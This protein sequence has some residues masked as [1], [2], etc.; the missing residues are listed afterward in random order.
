MAARQCR[1]S[2]QPAALAVDNVVTTCIYSSAAACDFW[3]QRCAD[4]VNCNLCLAEMSN[5]DNALEAVASWLTTACQEALHDRFA[6]SYLISITQGCPGISACRVAVTE[7]VKADGGTFIACINGSAPSGYTTFCSELMQ[8][9]SIDSKC[10]SCPTSVHTINAVVFATSMVGGVSAV[11]CLAVA[12]T[13]VA[14]RRDRVSMRDRIVVGLMMANA[15]YSTANAIPLNA[16]R[17]SV[18]H[19]G[20]LA[21]SF[22]AIRFGRAWWFCGKYGLVSFEL[23]IL[24]ASIQALLG[25][26]SAVSARTEAATYAA[27]CAIAALAFAVFYALCSAINADG[28]NLNA[29]NEAYTNAY[30][31]ASANDDLDDDEP[32]V[33]ASETYTSARDAYDN[34]V[35]DMLVVW[36]VVVGVAVGL[37][38]VVRALHHYALRT[39]RT[40]EAEVARAE[41]ADEWAATRQS[42]WNARRSLLETRRD[43]FNEVAK[44]LEPYIAV[45]VVFA[46]PAVIMSTPFCQNRSGAIKASG[47]SVLDNADGNDFTYGTCD[48][49]CEFVLAFRSLGAVAVYLLARERRAELVAVRSTW[50]K[51]CVRAMACLRCKQLPYAPLDDHQA[52]WHEMQEL[53]QRSVDAA[54]GTNN[55]TVVA[56]AAASENVASWHMNESDITLVKVLGSGAFGEVWEGVKKCDGHRVA[57]KVMRA[58][59]VDEDGDIVDLNADEDFRKECDA[60][61]RVS[62]PHL[63]TFYGFGTTAAGSGFIVTELMLGGSLEDV[64]HDTERKLPWET[65]MKIALQVALGMEHLHQRHMLHRDL[66]SANVL[67]DEELRAKVSDF[68]LS[69]VVRPARRQVVRSSFSGVTRLLPDGLYINNNSQKQSVLSLARIAVSFS[70]SGGNLTKAAGTLL[71]M[72]PEVYRGDQHYTGAVDVYSFGIVLWELATRKT[73]WAEEL[74]SN[75]VEFIE[76]LNSALQ[77]GRRPELPDTMR[78]EQSAFVAVMEKCWAG[79]PTDRPAFSKVV[80]DL[81]ACV[82][83]NT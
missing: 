33:S 30:N 28:Y 68:G 44:P 39:L 12:A 14:H 79:D 11:A 75:Q 58:G 29:E 80:A 20:R 78:T 18:I 52:A 46:A 1:G 21:M 49:W 4:N 3:R 65:R 56:T 74:P 26:M 81:A 66:K 73:P 19:Y 69:R 77:K 70:D 60:L 45:F 76:G 50:R 71:W 13:I 17:T 43:A 35:R 59:A 10:Q 62:S 61:Q 38:I 31:H 32:S 16:L 54:V 41:A 47:A 48:V 82:R 24:G 27:C 15:V 53:E 37:W 8:E 64:L 63:L 9:Y 40:E 42:A 57:V 22:D 72:A 6:A 36:D 34:L 67:L 25:G 2:T 7:G 55:I 23:V 5:G 51:L 83:G